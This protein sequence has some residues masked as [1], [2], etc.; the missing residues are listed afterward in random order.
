ME[1]K[2]EYTP[3]R[4]EQLYVRL[5]PLRQPYLDRARECAKYT[6]P[7]LMPPLG[8]HS[9]TKLPTPYQGVGARGVNNLASKLLLVLLPPNSP[10]FRLMV[11]EFSENHFIDAAHKTAIETALG[12]IE[13]G[14]MGEIETSSDRVS[15]FEALKHLLVVGNCLAYMP[16]GDSM[17]VFHLDR[18]VIKRDPMGKVLHIV[19]KE[20]IDYT[21]LPEEV[22]KLLPN[23]PEYSPE[24]STKERS[25]EIYTHLYRDKN[26]WRLYQEIQGILIPNSVSS[27]QFDKCPYIP[28]RYTKIDGEDYGRSFV[29]EYL[30]DLKTLEGL[31]KAVTE[32]A[33]A[34][35]KI[36]FLVNPNGTTRLKTIAE[37]PNCAIREGNAEDVTI[38]QSNKFYDFKTASER[39]DKIEERLSY[40][41][42]LNS[43][44]Q[45]QG[46]RVTAEEIR[47]M[48]AELED[49][50]GG[51]YSI[52]S[53]E[54][55][56]PYVNRKMAQMQASGKLPPLPK[57]VIKPSII[58]GLEALGRGQDLNKLDLFIS[59][60]AQTLGPEALAQ[61]M[62][63]GEYIARRA[64]ALGID[65]E[66]LI[67]SEEE[68]QASQAQ[69][70]QQA[71]LSQFG[72]EVIKQA[73]PLIQKGME[74]A[75]G[76]EAA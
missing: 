52:L 54:F 2:K 44:I 22:L 19:T 3:G 61:Y 21:A 38:L 1:I 59:G 73:G 31:T 29:D 47:Y 37:A 30:G 63:I 35:A 76:T 68:V 32:G 75:N 42:M 51:L 50:L 55:Q 23:E 25:C 41:F 69:A 66:G 60:M 62:N 26:R 65:T 67:R 57:G 24:G 39:M 17:Q 11:D 56:L 72:P 27:F 9:T 12:K 7:S 8:I 71:M 36:L 5:E 45:R 58:T 10:F 15:T 34:A 49:S 33:A 64:T 18:Y 14:V 4:A 16:K 13:R 74:N 53:Q 28:L 46:E 40:A 70:Q 43:S 6:I 48:A 20:T